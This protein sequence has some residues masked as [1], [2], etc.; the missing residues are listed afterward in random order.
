MRGAEDLALKRNY[1]LITFNTD[2][3]VEREKKVLSLLRQRRVDGA[4]LVLAPNNG[5]DAHIRDILNSGLP[6]VCLDRVPAGIRVDSV[7]VDNV[8]GSRECVRHLIDWDIE[9]LLF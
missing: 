1:L 7:S 8:G 6:T 4:L 3:N 2:D 5:N 9:A